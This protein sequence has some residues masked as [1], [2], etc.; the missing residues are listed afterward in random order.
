[1]KNVLIITYYW[2]P[3]GGIAVQRITKFCKHLTE[4][5]WRPIILT[6]RNGNYESIDNSLIDDIVHIE[7]VYHAY[8]IEPHIFYNKIGSLIKTTKKDSRSPSIKH[9]KR[10]KYATFADYIRLNLFIPDSRIGWLH[11]AYRCGQKIIKTHKPDLIFSTAPPY[12]PHLIAM[13]LHKHSG[14][15]WIADFRDPWVESTLYNTVKRLGLVKAINRRLE[16]KV[17]SNATALTFT[18]PKL[19]DHYIN[20]SKYDFSKKAH[21]ITNG[22]D[23]QDIPET[24]TSTSGRFYI[25]YFGSLYTRRF[26]PAFFQTLSQLIKTNQELS[27]N[28]CLRFIGN[29]DTEI[30]STLS[31]II[32]NNNLKFDNYIPYKNAIKRLY[33]PQLLLLIIDKVPFNDNITLGKV[34]DYLPTGNPIIGI[35]PTKGDTALI[36]QSTKTGKVFDYNDQ[37]SIEKYIIEKYNRWKEGNL[38]SSP[39][40]LSTFHRINLTKHLADIFDRTTKPFL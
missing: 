3:A 6:V 27:N 18:G 16:R 17:V 22:Y 11:N 10:S 8:S 9:P 24:I 12:T 37:Q 33:A 14:I 31:S 32:P 28:L 35:G 36:I 23:T 7:N 40:N 13:K 2:P 1:M 26:H 21:V 39:C 19:R 29:V 30:K 4:F 15:P 25:T 20:D 34:F 5:G 38:H